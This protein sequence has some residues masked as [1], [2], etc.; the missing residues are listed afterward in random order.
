MSINLEQYAEKGNA[1][2]WQPGSRRCAAR[3][4]IV[5]LLAFA[6]APHALAWGGKVR[7]VRKYRPGQVMVYETEIRTTATVRSNPPT[8]KVFLPPVP[9]ALTSRHRNT[10]RVGKVHPDGSAD[11]ENR[12]DEF[13]M[14][15]ELPEHVPEEVRGDAQEAAEEFTRRLKG[16]TLTAR[17]DRAGRLLD[18]GGAEEV[19]EEL[20]APLRDSLREVLK[21]FL[22]QMGGNALYPDHRVRPGEEWK[23]KLSEPASESYPYAMEGESTL[24]YV[25]KTR[26]RGVKAAII[27]FRFTNALKPEMQKLRQEGPLSELE[28]QGMGIDMQIQGQG[29]GR[30]LVALDDGRVLQN[31]STLLQ[32]L[33]ALL[34]GL[35]G[36]PLSTSEPVSLQVDSETRLEMDG[37]GK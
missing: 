3:V 36:V 25:G 21:L 8:L 33:N 29:E 30:I 28:S 4:A 14:Q 17:Y 26:Y 34:K 16:R 37:S 35:P 23:R 12:F 15:S 27:D 18:F 1:A 19:L 2:R 10:V 5:L 31:H 13:E 9:S 22:D 24:R 20:D 11:I 32:T 6:G 7:L